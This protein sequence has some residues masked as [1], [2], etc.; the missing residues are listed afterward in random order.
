MAGFWGKK[1]NEQRPAVSAEFDHALMREVMQ[2]ELVRVKALII[3]ALSLL[4]ILWTIDLTDPR[5]LD[6]IWR[7][8]FEPRYLNYILIPF[9][10]FELWVHRSIRRHLR[11]DRDLALIRRY[12]GV[13]I[14]TSLP[15]VALAV[16]VQKMGPVEALGFVMPFAYFIFIILS[17]L[18]L[19]FW[20]STFTGFVAAAELFYIAMYYHPAIT[21][22]PPPDG[23]YHGARSMMLLISGVLAGAVGVQLRRQFAA[24]IVAATARDRVTNLFGQH[25]SPQVA[26]RLLLEGPSTDS[27][28]RR[29]AVMFVDFRSF[30]AAAR[31]RSPKDVVDRLD[32]AF[33]VL[34]EILDRHGGIVN[35]FLGDG[36]LAL[37]GAP[38]EVADAAHHAVAA[39]REMLAAMEIINEASHWPLRI[40]I[41]IHVGEVVAG[42][43][44]SPRRKEYTVI[45]D[46]VN[47]ASRLEA[48]NKEFN[49]QLLISAAV[50]DALGEDGSD[51]VSLGEVP[52]KGYDHPMMVWQLG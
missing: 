41:G 50:R 24:S 52:V 3:T 42:N 37:F 8:R 21:T 19:D 12:L 28:I 33:A 34:V 43:I 38:F 14:E 23:F 26:E 32:G 22:D 1:S 31:S 46:T 27:D 10:L 6:R 13:L 30:T 11:L 5:G 36:F 16:H 2:T 49:S 4:I 51:A 15:T 18:R 39:A 25:V 35:K 48:L 45:G 40:G 7:G 44:G 20:L 9:I 17:T 29:V 47:F